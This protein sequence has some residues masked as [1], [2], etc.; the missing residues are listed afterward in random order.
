MWLPTAEIL[1]SW[2]RELMVATKP[3]LMLAVASGA[4][5]TPFTHLRTTNLL[6][7]PGSTWK[8]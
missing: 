8:Q 7:R 4:D 3:L 1:W 6:P 5:S 2:G